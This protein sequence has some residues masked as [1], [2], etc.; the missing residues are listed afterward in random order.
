MANQNILYTSIF[1]E[2]LVRSGLKHVCLAPGSRNTPLVLAFT[3]RT[4]RVQVYSHLDERSMAFFGLGLALASDEPVALVC[5][6]GTAGANFY[7]AVIEAHQSCVP[8]IIL[9]AD[10]PHELRHS[11]ANQTIDQIKLYGDYVL[12]FVDVALPESNPPDV[13]LRN[14]RTLAARAYAKA[15]GLRKGAVHINWPFRK[16][17]EPTD[18][19]N[20]GIEIPDGAK[21]WEDG[22]PFTW[23]NSKHFRGIGQFQDIEFLAP[24]PEHEHGLIVCG[25]RTDQEFLSSALSALV[26]KLGYPIVCDP[27]SSL[28]FAPQA[29]DK[30]RINNGLIVTAYE[31]FPPS[32]VLF[33][34]EPDVVFRLGHVPTSKWLNNYLAAISPKYHIQISPSGDWSDDTHNVTH[35]LQM[36]NMALSRIGLHHDP[37]KQKTPFAQQWQAVDNRAWEVMDHQIETGEYFDGGVVYDSLD[38][39]PDLSSLFVGNSLP[40]RHLDQ[41]GKPNGKQIDVYANRGASGIDGNISTALGTGAA[42]PDRPLVAIVG[43]I[44]FY[45]DM[46]GLL[47]VHRCGIPITIVLL[48]NNGGGIF[49]RLPISQFDPP[50]T[51]YFVTSHGLDFSHAAK[52]YGLKYVR[53]EG[54]D[55]FRDAFSQSVNSRSSTIVE[56]PTDA[57]HDL[58]R[59]NEIMQVIHKRLSELK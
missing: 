46:N 21:A 8:L 51:D 25:P 4:D 14:L 2:E 35:F 12:W 18:V 5:S 7:P 22:S 10:R 47:A 13:T 6:S 34:F 56:V 42:R 19:D 44:T 3:E 52:M 40:I 41:F 26:L 11:G 33:D 37:K 20:D 28:R 24:I 54:R 58:K 45:H 55:A 29:Q 16:P 48:N 9:T 38:L 57:R 39:I 53:A 43:D 59:R 17:L 23:T 1:V 49:H 50:F 36:D 32:S 31:N 15:N 30:I 27:L